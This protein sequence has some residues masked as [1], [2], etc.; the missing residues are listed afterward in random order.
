[1]LESDPVKRDESKIG[2]GTLRRLWLETRL[3]A[4]NHVIAHVPLHWVRLGFYRRVMRLRVGARSSINMG[5]RFD[6]PGRLTVG[7]A[8]T[9]NA[10]C[11]LDARGG[12]RIGSN[13]SISEEVVILTAEH[14]LQARGFDGREEAVI[15]DD[16]VF[17]GTRA[18]I[19][20]GVRL[21]RGCAVAAGAVVTKDVAAHTIVGG[22]PARVIGHRSHDLNYQ[23]FYRRLFQ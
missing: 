11:R 20:P 12:L 19:L 7:E 13:V 22:V 21:G 4:A 16:Y 5:A 14:D 23:V 15:I 1:M 17:V 10:N 9:I 3:Y 6:T 2:F 18:M 8:S